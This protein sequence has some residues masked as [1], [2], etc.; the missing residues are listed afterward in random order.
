VRAVRA[1][2]QMQRAISRI[3]RARLV[4]G[5]FPAAIPFPGCASHGKT[6]RPSIEDDL[7]PQAVRIVQSVERM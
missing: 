4:P 5:G 6:L 2:G 3:P 7:K 1:I